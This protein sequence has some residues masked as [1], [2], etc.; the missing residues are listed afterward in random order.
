MRSAALR[1]AFSRKTTQKSAAPSAA[2]SSTTAWS[3]VTRGK[4][5]SGASCPPLTATLVAVTASIVTMTPVRGPAQRRPL[6]IHAL[7]GSVDARLPTNGAIRPNTLMTASDDPNS[8]RASAPEGTRAFASIKP[9]FVV[10]AYCFTSST[11]RFLARPS[12]AALDAT[13]ASSPT[14]AGLS[15]FASTPCFAASSLTTDAAR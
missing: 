1:S 15:R 13:G 7:A 6:R 9:R 14:P 11:R 8:T 10:P 5:S 12:S 4:V 2:T 3:T